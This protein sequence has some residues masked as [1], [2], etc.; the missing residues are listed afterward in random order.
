MSNLEC[1]N[2]RAVVSLEHHQDHSFVDLRAGIYGPTD[3][4]VSRTR[5]G[6]PCYGLC[7]CGLGTVAGPSISQDRLSQN[8]KSR[9]K[10]RP[11]VGFLHHVADEVL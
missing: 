10:T 8:K 4:Q 11:V 3:A 5:R 9:S 2:V 1:R 6:A 7:A